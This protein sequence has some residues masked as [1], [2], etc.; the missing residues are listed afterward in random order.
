MEEPLT[1]DNASDDDIDPTLLLESGRASAIQTLADEAKA[2]ADHSQALEQTLSDA[3]IAENDR[4]RRRN[5]VLLFCV[6]ALLVMSGIREYRASFVTGPKIDNI[7]KT[8]TG[9]LSNANAKLDEVVVYIH[10]QQARS[11]AGSAAIQAALTQI[12]QI[13]DLICASTDAVRQEACGE[14][15]PPPLATKPA[16]TTTLA[17]T[18]TT[19]TTIAP[20]VTLPNGK[21]KH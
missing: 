13:R 1:E 9:P 19:T 20:C 11:D 7:D 4:F 8:V 6:V 18:T 3:I 17:P 21:C 16:T 5:N 2:V 10:A 12:E 14:T 15:P